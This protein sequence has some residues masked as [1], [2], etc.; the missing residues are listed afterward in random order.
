MAEMFRMDSRNPENM[1]DLEFTTNALTNEINKL[2][3]QI[4]T[5]DARVQKLREENAAVLRRVLTVFR[6]MG[7]IG[8]VRYDNAEELF[9]DVST[10][11]RGVKKA[12]KQLPSRKY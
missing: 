8:K 10:Y 1:T 5:K 3:K 4:R 2:R 7:F 6:I 12:L 9:E 11:A